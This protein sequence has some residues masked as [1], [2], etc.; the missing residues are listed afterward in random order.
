MINKFEN[1][2]RD[3]HN[4]REIVDSEL[5]KI[6]WTKPNIESKCWTALYLNSTF[7]AWE[8]EDGLH[9]LRVAPSFQTLGV[10]KDFKEIKSYL[11]ERSNFVHKSKL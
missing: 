9:L 4:M 11:W 3:L 7:E 6:R 2:S 8:K 1:F 5:G 10:F